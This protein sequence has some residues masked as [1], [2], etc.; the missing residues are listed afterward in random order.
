MVTNPPASTCITVP[1]E[2]DYVFTVSVSAAAGCTYPQTADITFTD[3][4]SHTMILY[5]QGT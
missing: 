5:V 3:R 2:S 1:P 4:F